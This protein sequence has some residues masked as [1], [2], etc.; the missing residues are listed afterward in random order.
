MAV[1]VYLLNY[2]MV[3]KIHNE[4]I[5]KLPFCNTSY[6]NHLHESLTQNHQIT[7]NEER[8]LSE[9]F[10]TFFFRYFFCNDIFFQ[11]LLRLLAQLNLGTSH[12]FA[13]GVGGGGGALRGLKFV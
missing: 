5:L 2:S 11:V 7:I 10:F 1:V 8:I 4:R 3:N 13:G 9:V 6:T 12:S